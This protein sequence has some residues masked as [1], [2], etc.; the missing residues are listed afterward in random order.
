MD[1]AA[2]SKAAAE[3]VLAMLRS[4]AGH[5]CGLFDT[6]ISHFAAVLGTTCVHAA[7]AAS[8]SR[9]ANSHELVGAMKEVPG[10][11][12]RL[13]TACLPLVGGDDD[14]EDEDVDEEEAAAA[15]P[16]A[17]PKVKAVYAHEGREQDGFKLIGFAQGEI[18]EL[19]KRREDGW[20]RV[21]RGD[22]QGWAPS[23]YLEDHAEP[24]ATPAPAP[25]AAKKRQ[26]RGGRVDE[27]ACEQ[28]TNELVEALSDA[29]QKARAVQLRDRELHKLSSQLASGLE[30]KLSA[31]QQSIMDANKLFSKLLAQ[32]K[33]TD[34]G[35]LL[36]VNEQLLN[37]AL[38][39]EESMRDTINA[40]DGMREALS[41]TR[42]AASLEEFNAK[43]QSWFEAL[44]ASVDSIHEGN[45]LLMEAIRCVLSRKGKHEE[46]QVATRSISAS[47]AQLAAISRMKSLAETKEEASQ[48]ALGK[49]CAIV[50][51]VGTELLAAARE[52]QDLALAAVLLEDF[53][54]LTA[55]QA[56]RLTM[57][58]QVNVLRLEKEVERERE[59]LG[60]LRRLNYE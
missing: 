25:A 41:R 45:P 31:A 46:L 18:L 33:A 54:E 39:L 53:T 20:S 32:T 14:E 52:S 6:K 5:N 21:K 38:R 51:E 36:E 56:K 24:A 10:L 8:V 28:L 3:E 15:A 11:T 16:S 13:L 48:G 17:T 29:V 27:A 22:E 9:A 26:A 30:D 23:S 50:I 19:V 37:I 2:Q 42:G 59:K 43:H 1:T 57:A 40:A 58:T 49:S 12:D 47:V 55:N 35:R 44:A 4:T 34:S 7:G 60:R